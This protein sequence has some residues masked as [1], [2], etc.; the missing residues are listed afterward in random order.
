M[1]TLYL[2]PDKDGKAFIAPTNVD[3][4]LM[5]VAIVDTTGLVCYAEEMLGLH[6]KDEAFNVRLCRYY[7]IVRRWLNEHRD[8]VLH[9]SFE[10]AHLS[11]ARQMLLWRDELKMAQ[12]D[13]RYE[14]ETTRLGALSAI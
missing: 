3:V 9:N 14:D 10:L 13:F 5:D 4:S 6:C 7:K 11:T 2:I 8:N 1:I 12:W